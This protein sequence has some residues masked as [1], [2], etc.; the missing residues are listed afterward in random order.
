MIYC[1]R[2]G[3]DYVSLFEQTFHALAFNDADARREL[4]KNTLRLA[5]ID[6]MLPAYTTDGQ[7][8]FGY[9]IAPVYAVALRETESLELT[10]ALVKNA[11]WWRRQRVS[12]GFSVPAYAYPREA[13]IDAGFSFD[14]YGAA[15]SPDLLSYLVLLYSSIAENTGDQMWAVSAEQTLQVLLGELADD[16]GFV[17]KGVLS[18]KTEHI[19]GILPY[20][21]LILGGRLPSNLTDKLADRIEKDD[22]WQ[23]EKD[24]PAVAL[25]VYGLLASG[26]RAAAQR[27]GDWY[28]SRVKL[29]GFVNNAGD[30]FAST[31]AAASYLYIVSALGSKEDA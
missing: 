2:R 26:R 30:E 19:S 23:I 7:V 4:L 11:G 27:V 10:R 15:L 28:V 6:G 8:Q 1:S 9:S 21:P 31:W 25:L 5:D 20:V 17:A 12:N 14:D 22:F 18:R 29:C 24:I 3:R 16:S 13:G